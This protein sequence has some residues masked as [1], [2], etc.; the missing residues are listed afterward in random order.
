IDKRDDAV[1]KLK[2][3]A[4]GGNIR[5]MEGFGEKSEADILHAIEEVKMT[6]NEKQRLLLIHAEEIA[7]RIIK[8]INILPGIIK[9]DALGSLR[10]RQ[11][12]I[13]DIDIAVASYESDEVIKHFLK[14]SEIDEV[15]A[16]GDKK[17]SV[18]LNNQIQVDLRVSEPEAYG[19]MVQYSTGNKQHNVL[20]RTYALENG[21]SLSEYGIKYK[22]KLELFPDEESFYNRLNLTWIPPE[23]RHGKSE[24]E[25]A[26]KGK[27][28]KLVTIDDIKGDMHTHT[29]ASDGLNTLAE[30]VNAAKMMGYQYIGISDHSP[31][32]QSRGYEE[33]VSIIEKQKKNIE[34][35]NEAQNDIKV[36]FG[37]EVNILADATLSLPDEIL[38]KLDYVVASIHTSFNQERDVV[39]G[40]LVKAAENPYVTIIG[41]PSGRLINEREPCDINW[42]SVFEAV[43]KH[44]K[45][46]EINCQPNRLDLVDD[47]VLE[48]VRLGIK[49][50]I[51]TDAHDTE[52]LNFMKYGIDV[53][54]RGFSERKNIIN[55]LS[56]EDLLENITNH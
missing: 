4:V 32:I 15:L 52:S 45:I 36:L 47:L 23:I 14:F 41:H 50:I 27:L 3:A 46:L 12:T 42:G 31:S 5:S 13:G 18:V 51:N 24:I 7:G 1:E 25:L 48:A 10:R 17:V 9:A 28:P 37:Y 54:R 26:I 39:T 40:R 22:G 30:M 8:H 38:S 11:A 53:A 16:R 35:I 21:M 6:K 56:Y 34:S 44:N 49:L 19:S 33:V 55:T 2:K 29:I 20:L 43:K